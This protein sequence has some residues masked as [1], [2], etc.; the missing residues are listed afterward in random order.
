M[1]TTQLTF[2]ERFLAREVLFGTFLKIPATMPAEIMGSVGYDFIVVDEEHAPFNRETTDR[3][4]LACRATGI[5]AIVR[6]Q[7]G[8]PEAILSA[9]DCGADGVLVPHVTD[10]ESASAIVAAGRYRTGKRGFAPTTRAGDFGRKSQADHME[11]EDSRVTLIAMIEDPEAVENI[12]EI[13]AIEGLDGVFIGRGDLGAAYAGQEG[14]PEHVRR[15]TERVHA[16]AWRAGR[17]VAILP[18]SPEDATAQARAGSTTFI[19]SSDQSFLRADADRAH[20]EISKAV[21]VAIE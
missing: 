10:A 21:G 1:T 17:P 9:L 8:A 12:D 2:R 5:A 3:I 11:T 18:G 13:L 16:A 4:I 15:A 14:A 6:V 7:S 19:I 20:T